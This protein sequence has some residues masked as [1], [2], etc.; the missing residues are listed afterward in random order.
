MFLMTCATPISVRV[1]QFHEW[2]W[3][4]QGVL[5]AVWEAAAPGQLQLPTAGD[6]AAGP[7]QHG[8]IIKISQKYV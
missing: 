3:A 1:E 7:L 4:G 6:G 8:E 2:F 5:A